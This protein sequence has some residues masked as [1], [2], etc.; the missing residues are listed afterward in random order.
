MILIGEVESA[1]KYNQT[2]IQASPVTPFLYFSSQSPLSGNS[3]DFTWDL[4]QNVE[5]HSRLKEFDSE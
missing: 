3:L 4:V 1:V 2:Q 5:A